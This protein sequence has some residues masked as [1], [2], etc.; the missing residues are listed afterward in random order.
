MA[1]LTHQLRFHFQYT[2]WFV[3]K[4]WC[5]QQWFNCSIGPF[6]N[7]KLLEFWIS[8]TIR[9]RRCTRK[10]GLKRKRADISNN[11]V[12]RVAEVS[13]I[14]VTEDGIFERLYLFQGLR[15]FC[16]LSPCPRRPLLHLLPCNKFLMFVLFFF[17]LFFLLFSPFPFTLLRTCESE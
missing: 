11:L 7:T 17:S 4:F 10:L 2:L 16:S 14:D 6:Q 9:I 12:Q 15:K 8:D 3:K 5:A 1:A 13:A